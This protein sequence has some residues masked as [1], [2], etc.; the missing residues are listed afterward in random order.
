MPRR[1]VF[2]LFFPFIIMG[3]AASS[4]AGA[5]PAG[6]PPSRPSSPVSGL[7]VKFKAAAPPAAPG[8]PTRLQALAVRSGVRLRFHRNM[9]GK[10]QVLALPEAMSEE[11]AKEI[12]RLVAADPAVEYAEPDSIMFPLLVPNDPSYGLQWHYQSPNVI[13]GGANVEAA[14]DVTTGAPNQV[15]AVVDTGYVDHQDLG[16]QIV[17]GYDM[18]SLDPAGAGPTLCPLGAA[19]C[20]ANDGN[21]RDADAH[22]PGDGITAAAEAASGGWFSNQGCG[23]SNSTWHGSHVAGTVGAKSNNSSGVTGI[24]WNG[25]IVP[26]R[27]LGRCGGTLSDIADGIRWAA[28][29]DIGG[30]VPVNTNPAKVINLSIGGDGACGATYQNAITEATGSPYFANVVVAAGNGGDDGIGDDVVNTRPA[31]CT[32]VIT[33]AST[34]RNGERAV[35]SNFG[36][37]VEIAAPGGNMI[38]GQTH[39]VYST[40]N[41]GAQAPTASPAGDTFAYYQG[42]SMAAPHV[43]GIISLMLSLNPNLSPAQVLSK[44][45]ASAR[46]FPTGTGSDCTTSICGT[47]IIDAYAA[48]RA[49]GTAPTASAGPDQ[50][51]LFGQG[52]TLDGTGSSDDNSIV[53]YLWT[54]TQGPAV[55]LSGGGTASA[56]FTA[57]KSGVLVFSLRVTDDVGLTGIDYSTVTVNIVAPASVSALT[58]GVSS[59]TW[60]WSAVSGAASYKIFFATNPSNPIANPGSPS[61]DLTGLASNSTFSMVVYGVRDDGVNGPGAVS[62]TTATLAGIPTAGVLSV[63]VTSATVNFTPAAGASGYFLQASTAANFTGAVFSSVTNNGATAK[64]QVSGLSS[65]T[66]YFLRL[67]SLN[68]IGGA[69]PSNSGLPPNIYTD[70]DI[71]APLAAPFGAVAKTEILMNWLLG[72]NPGALLYRAEASQDPAFVTAVSSQIGV[73]ISSAI[74][75]GLQPNAT[76]FF[77][78]FA[79]TVG[80]PPRAGPSLSLGPVATLGLSPSTATPVFSN[81]F[82]SSLTVSWTSG[83]NPSGTRYEIELSSASDFLGVP[84]S[85]AGTTA[86]AAT[87]IGLAPNTSYYARVRAYSHG[88]TPSPIEFLALGSTA[89]HCVDPFELSPNWSGVSSSQ[90]TFHVQSGGNPS[91]TAF[92]AQI[93]SSAVFTTITGEASGT[94]AGFAGAAVFSGLDSNW[95]YYFRLRA[96]NRGGIPTSWVPVGSSTATF[97]SPPGSADPAVV[98]DYVFS[99]SMQR[100]WTGSANKSGTSYTARFSRDPAFGTV[101]YTQ[102]TTNLYSVPSS[103]LSNTTYYMQVRALSLDAP[104]PNSA[105]VDFA[106]RSTLTQQCPNAPAPYL[107]VTYTS[108]TVQWTALPATPQF[109]AAEGTLVTFSTASN[110]GGDLF[111]SRI[112]PGSVSKGGVSGLKHSTV[113]YLRIGS[114]NWEDL[115]MSCTWGSTRTM[116]PQ[117]SSRTIDGAAS[118]SVT[119]PYSQAQSLT[120]EIPAGALPLGTALELNANVE[121]DLPALKSNQAAMTSLGDGVGLK[122]TSNAQPLKAVAI[123]MKLVLPPGANPRRLALARYDDA[124]D[125]WTLLKSQVDT[126]NLILTGWTNHFSFFA[127]FLVDPGS[128]VLDVNI[129]PIPWE[130]LSDDSQHNSPFL[131]FT[132]LPPGARVRIYNLTGELVDDVTAAPNGILSWEG[133]NRYGKKVGTGTYLALIEFDGQRAVRRFIVIR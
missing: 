76:Y 30:G 17:G 72:A 95:R 93:S 83:G 116:V 74:F 108:A 25:K 69:Y 20:R 89:T 109:V 3:L 46:A 45:Q 123:I 10:A 42:T 127:P 4:T 88:G 126:G 114:L 61:Y 101:D 130:P 113:Y 35:Y 51:V 133:T 105:W 67:A 103:L 119:P 58:K 5:Q 124:A 28:G 112:Y 60:N 121:L 90:L 12:A 40:L 120:V 64:L 125:Q 111:Q 92:Q 23:T 87:F 70:S 14:W 99:D 129:F 117:L 97:P 41:S 13:T 57:N 79:S 66:S 102:T 26:V 47:G 104:N 128:N 52:V 29:V 78:V 19:D 75:G 18:V 98:A 68:R 122:I 15:V 100:N 106:P 1:P 31:N 82:R 39:G 54:Q 33:V 110:F 80:P 115:E 96:V 8:A 63:H 85:S 36:S 16:T 86:V 2:S 48:V 32:G 11:R 27:V 132:K 131:T 44:M 34:G 107:S 59:I 84:V 22:D 71:V 21:G 53:S 77:R 81:V 24:N 65:S 118:L 49:A 73:D 6:R 38:Q 94:F 56:S 50:A 9:S 7:I 37:L 55:S 62:P 91:G 43:S